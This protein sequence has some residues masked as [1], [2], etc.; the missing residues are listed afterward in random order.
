MPP[1]NLI[2][3]LAGIV[4][5]TLLTTFV[6]SRARKL[7][8]RDPEAYVIISIHGFRAALD[9]LML[10]LVW[11]LVSPALQAPSTLFLLGANLPSGYVYGCLFAVFFWINFRVRLVLA[12]H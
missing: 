7:Y 9:T 1:R 2:V 11:V 6:A 5:Y 4:L 8:L 3:P 12:R 10:A